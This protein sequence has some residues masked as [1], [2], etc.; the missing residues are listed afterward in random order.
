MVSARVAVRASGQRVEVTGLRDEFSGTWVNPDGS[1]TTELHGGQQ[2]FRDPASGAWREVDLD[3]TVGRDGAVV[4]KGHPLG[5]RLPGSASAA[6]ADVVSVGHGTVRG[7]DGKKVDRQVAL[8]WDKRLPEPVLEGR[9]ATY[10][11]MT[12]GVDLVVESRRSGFEQFFV[13]DTPAAL[14]ASGPVSWS[15]TLR[16]KG[17]T[18]A[19]ADDGGVTF[20]DAA[21]AVVSRIPPAWAWDAVV[22]ERSGDPVNVAPVALTVTQVGR[23]VARLTVTPDQEWL[24]DPAR[25]FPVT[26]DPTYA[27]ASVAPGFDTYVQSNVSS[28]DYSTSTELRVGTYDGSTATRSFVNFPTTAIRGKQ[29][30]SA[31]LSLYEF[32]SWSCTA[33]VV[34]AQSTS[35]VATASTRWSNQPAVTG[36]STSASFAKGY[37]ASC[38]DGRVSIPVTAQVQA[39]SGSTATTQGLRLWASETSTSGWKKFYSIEGPYDPVL[40]FTYNRKPNAAVAPYASVPVL[41]DYTPPGSTVASKFTP[42]KRPTLTSKASD[43]DGNTVRYKIEIWDAGKSSLVSTCSTPYV[44]SGAAA[45][46]AA[47]ADLADNASYHARTAVVDD[48][49][50]WNGTWS[51]WTTFATAIGAPTAPVISCP[52]PYGNGSWAADAP[53]GST[54]CTITAAGTGTTAPGYVDV[55]VDGVD[56]DTGDGVASWKRVKITPS[57]DPGVAKT[58]VSVPLTEGAHAVV[59]RSVSR[60]LVVSASRTYQFGFGSASMSVPAAGTPLS[61]TSTVRITASGPPRGTGAAPTAQLQWRLAGSAAAA[62]TTAAD[63]TVPASDGVY[64]VSTSWNTAGAALDAA[65]GTRLNDRVPVLLDVQVCFTYPAP[66]GVQCTWKQAGPQQV[67][68]VPH[69]FGGAYPTVAAGPG[70][71]ALWTGEF[72]TAATDVS[73][74]GYNGTGL[75]ISRSHSTYAGAADPVRNVFGPGWTAG[76][77]GADAGAAGYQVI[78]STAVDGTIALVDE[79]GAALVYAQPGGTRT[80]AKT[81]TYTPAS[82]DTAYANATLVLSGSGTAATLTLTEEDGTT[83]TWAPRAAPAA[84]ADTVWVPASV[85]E[86][87]Q[88]SATS[89]TRNADGLVT[90][91]LAPVPPGVT[92]GATTLVAGC[93][94]LHL[95]YGQPV[96]GHTR[97]VRVEAEAWDPTKPG[98]PGMH[99]VPVATYTYETT[100]AARLV[101][102][103]DPRSGLATG[104]GYDGTTT[105]LATLT[106]PGLA[107]VTL[108]YTTASN[109]ARLDTV[110]RP[111]PAAA[112]GGTATLARVVYDMDPTTAPPA[113][114]PDLRAAVTDQWGQ[115]EA[116][117]Y[118]AAVLGEDYPGTGAPTGDAWRYAEVSYTDGRGRTVN[119]ATFGAGAWQV[120]ATGYDT[121]DNVVRQLDADAVTAITAQAAATGAPVDA[122]ALATLTVYNPDGTLVTDVYGPTRTVALPG[123]T[124]ASGRPHTHTDYDQGAP[125]GGT[126]PATGGPYNLPTTVTVATVTGDR[127]VTLAHHATT[128]TGYTPVV[129]GTGDGWAFGIPTTVTTRMGVGGVASAA[130]ITRVTVLDDQ[131]RVSESRQPLSDGADAGTARTVYYTAG[132]NPADA[133]C[134]NQPAWAGS[135][136]RTH[137]AAA[138]SSGPGLPDARTTG[139]S[140]W[141]APTTVTETSGNVTRTTRTGYLPDG[142]VQ[143]TET[144]LAGI[145]AGESKPVPVITTGYDEATGL[146]TTTRAAYPDGTTGTVATGYDAW[147]RPVSYTDAAGAVTT[148]VYDAAGR[149]A[150]T[151]EASGETRYG[152]GTDSRGRPEYRPLPTSVTVTTAAG[153]T[154]AAFAGAYD[155]TGRLVEQTLPGGLTQAWSYDVAGEPVALTYTGPVVDPGTGATSTG[156]WLA[157]SQDNDALGR[158]VTEYTPEGTVFDTSPDAAAYHRRYGYDGAGRLVRV[159]DRTADPATGGL[160]GV[161][162]A[163]ASAGCATRD[164]AF[165]PNGRRTALTTRSS[166]AGQPC[167]ATTDPAATTKTWGY[168]TADRPATA[169]DSAPYGYD[170]LGRVTTL[171]AA[172]TPTGGGDAKLGYYADDAAWTITAGGAKQTHDYDPA[173]R[174]ALATTSD[175]T[176]GAVTRTL[177]R[178]YADTSDNPALTIETLEASG[179]DPQRTTT[180]RYLPGLTGDLTATHTL[181]DATTELMLADP[182][183]DIT[184][185]LTLP[186]TGTPAGID[187]WHDTDEYGNPRPG[188]PTGASPAG[189]GWH[190]TKERSTDTPAG[191]TL[192]GARLYNPLT[193]HFTS[194][195]PVPGGNDT[196]YSYPNDPQNLMDLDGLR[197]ICGCAG[198]AAYS[199]RGPN[200]TIRGGLGV[201]PGIR[202]TGINPG[203]AGKTA[204]RSLRMTTHAKQR[205]VGN[206][207][208]DGGVNDAALR[209]ALRNPVRIMKQSRHTV[210]FVGREARVVLNIKTKRIV[211]AYPTQSSGR[212]F[213][214]RGAR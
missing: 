205:I 30:Q 13:L 101:S 122:D 63:L 185:T 118:G 117:T 56:L 55:T 151:V 98:G 33:A 70:Q 128:V 36:T 136:C 150:K 72:N 131:G 143:R 170:P 134:G 57:S 76:L 155:G 42:S 20:T 69:A 18:A 208:G 82:E 52:A 166:A 111:R 100:G 79:E 47:S 210:L 87:G 145:P 132:A 25:V 180:T 167:P 188:T 159:E 142:R 213:G 12:P 94:A 64:T 58:T 17:L 139:Y 125:G 130:D 19:Q 113:G 177:R 71:V 3:L 115:D 65:T 23:G 88:P 152:Y 6:G 85:T 207:R 140:M 75:S 103:A 211:T 172:D 174:R 60:T 22:D 40:S 212:R 183:G 157:W 190:G 209:S 92:C 97:L 1:L 95:V 78:D 11:E 5:L 116:P 66:L 135:V 186:A 109:R 176:T 119:T 2:R 28:T 123:G 46:C 193:A 83:T 7:R 127:A 121:H 32:H 171:P 49:G 137:P 38:P 44:A 105:R 147:G 91:V 162:D 120:T 173:G 54:T 161:E 181:E 67:L 196:A 37:S 50:L 61:T 84:G 169:P 4:A 198:R 77:D 16:T 187:T 165:D 89:F 8:A 21:G 199:G 160:D 144:T 41:Y 108:T 178:V 179:L 39:W 192:M 202:S 51:A 53:G 197:W 10:P 204:A 15:F 182:H 129:A 163:Q 86:P 73:V 81:G 29:V 200:S 106:P 35:G 191:L 104:Y 34:Y 24:R 90:R 194:L 93:R 156:A 26:V 184:A 141:L 133:E 148:T 96:T 43:P 110:T 158:V 164:Y 201:R 31:S 189:Y 80:L 146:A 14:P 48:Q 112:G 62:W 214:Q 9:R 153:A 107:P 154:V 68:R 59:A 74:P 206:S 102:V 149:L 168:D 126:N 124:L 175:T 99:R 195:D 203:R 45:S 114:L 138:P 27:S